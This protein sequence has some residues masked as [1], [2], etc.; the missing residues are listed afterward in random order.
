MKLLDMIFKNTTT[1]LVKR[2]KASKISS[3]E[4]HPTKKE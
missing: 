3:A 2:E 1:P 4:I